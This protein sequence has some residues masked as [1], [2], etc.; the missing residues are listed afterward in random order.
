MTAGSWLPGSVRRWWGT[1]KGGGAG[2][3]EAGRGGQGGGRGGGS[4]GR[5]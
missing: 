5:S 4:V 2:Y 1:Y 3:P